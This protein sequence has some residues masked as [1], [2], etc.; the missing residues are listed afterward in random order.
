[1]SIDVLSR[2]RRSVSTA[3]FPK[4]DTKMEADQETHGGRQ[5]LRAFAVRATDTLVEWFCGH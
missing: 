5:S 4:S 2:W 1:M 3:V